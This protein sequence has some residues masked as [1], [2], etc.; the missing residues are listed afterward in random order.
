MCTTGDECT[1]GV[2]GCA[3]ERR[4]EG[5]EEK[6]CVEENCEQRIMRAEMR[7]KKNESTIWGGWNENVR[8]CRVGLPEDHHL[9]VTTHHPSIT[10]WKLQEAPRE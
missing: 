5:R 1:K 4:E 8:M 2:G 9:Q 3:K 7:H 10:V 6:R